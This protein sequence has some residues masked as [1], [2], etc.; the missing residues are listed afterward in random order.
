MKT[1]RRLQAEASHWMQASLRWNLNPLGLGGAQV[2][3]GIVF[4]ALFVQSWAGSLSPL[5]CPEP[6][7][8]SPSSSSVTLGMNSQGG[9]GT[10]SST[11]PSRTA[12]HSSADATFTGLLVRPGLGGVGSWEPYLQPSQEGRPW[13]MGAGVPGRPGECAHSPGKTLSH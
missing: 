7:V 4:K 11:L 2:D 13:P 12:S 1:A 10:V 5:G 8:C 6:S 3:L 9:A